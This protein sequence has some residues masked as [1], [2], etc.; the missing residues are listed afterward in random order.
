MLERY[1]L[2]E[3]TN[4]WSDQFR[5]RTWFHIE[6]NACSAKAQLGEVA[7]D[8][9][10]ALWEAEPE[11]FDI[12]RI[13]QIEAQ[14]QHESIAFQTYVEEIAGEQC[15]GIF[16][17]GLTSSDVLDTCF[18]FQLNK[19]SDI[20][21]SKLHLL[22]KEFKRLALENRYTPCVGR[23][24]GVHGE[25]ITFGLKMLRSF[26]ET[27]RNIKRME[28]AKK[29]ISVGMISGAM[30]TYSTINPNVEQ[31]VCS[32]MGLAAETI[33]SQIIP[34]DRHAMYFSTL[35]VVA[36]TLERISIELRQLQITE[37]GEIAEPFSAKQKGS[38]AM[39]HKKNPI[40]LEN[41]TGLARLI[42]TYVAAALGNVSLWQERDM[43]H[44]S[45]ERALGPDTTIT[46]DF[47]IHR[48]IRI[49]Q[50]L[51]VN[52][53]QMTANL[54]KLGGITYSH[55]IMITLI[56][57]GASKEEA[58]RLVQEASFKAIE[59]RQNLQELFL[60]DK[61]ILNW[62]TSRE[63]SDL[64]EPEYFLKEVDGI[65]QRVLGTSEVVTK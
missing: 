57:K 42:Q 44:S 8:A 52:S 31:Y 61:R 2:P 21:L 11:T 43:S 39:P 55:R 41:V 10:R 16:H 26:A 14:V 65:F 53:D 22:A 46:L 17:R 54:E 51:K 63:L 56:E 7:D 6:A 3:M 62:V 15:Q 50:G 24:H 34:R 1:S 12:D 40:L 30:G 28:T 13:K 19:A 59:T 35:G 25:P 20:I 18:N 27:Q 32:R 64:F 45:V 5:L 47:A 36:A 38:S 9:V 37:I 49:L 58:Y 4:I 29:E 33:S 48:L 60:Q 23:S